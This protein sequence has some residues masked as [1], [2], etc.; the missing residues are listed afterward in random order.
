MELLAVH[1]ST[2]YPAAPE[3][4]VRAA[5]PAAIAERARAGP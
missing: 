4:F 1:S 2:M 5:S 3:R